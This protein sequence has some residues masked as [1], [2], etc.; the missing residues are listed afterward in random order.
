MG[1]F[2]TKNNKSEHKINSIK[3]IISWG[4]SIVL[5]ATLFINCNSDN[6]IPQAE[7]INGTWSLKNVNGGFTSVD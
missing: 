4:I 5:S 6:E 2:S 1:K 7:T 3:R